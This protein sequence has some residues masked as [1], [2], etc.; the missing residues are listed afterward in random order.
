MDDFQHVL[1]GNRLK[2]QPVRGVV[3]RGYCFGVAVD[4][5]GFIAVFTHGQGG[6]YATVIE[7]DTLADTVGTAA[8]HQDL[9]AISGGGLA[10]LFIG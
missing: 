3:V 1:Q 8:E 7:F 4:H 2:V 10:L 9:V 5:D 6:V